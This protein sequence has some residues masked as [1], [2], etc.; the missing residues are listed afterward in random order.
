MTPCPQ[1]RDNSSPRAVSA[2]QSISESSATPDSE[3]T[4]RQPEVRPTEDSVIDLSDNRLST[5]ST[6]TDGKFAVQPDKQQGGVLSHPQSHRGQQAEQDA[7][8]TTATLSGA[9]DSDMP[10]VNPPTTPSG[11][12]D[13]S[14]VSEGTAPEHTQQQLY[15]PQQQSPSQQP[16][17][18]P[19]HAGGISLPGSSSMVSPGSGTM[20][21]DRSGALQ[22][23][24]NSDTMLL[25]SPG[26]SKGKDKA[27]L[28]R[29][30]AAAKAAAKA[31]TSLQRSSSDVCALSP[32]SSML[33]LLQRIKR[34][35]PGM[36]RRTSSTERPSTA[37][38][39]SSLQEDQPDNSPFAPCR[40]ASVVAM[41]KAE[42]QVEI[43][44]PQSVMLDS[45]DSNTIGV[46]SLGAWACSQD[47]QQAELKQQHLAAHA[48]DEA[49]A[50]HDSSISVHDVKLELQESEQPAVELKNDASCTPNTE[51]NTP[52]PTAT[53]A[54]QKQ[55]APDTTS[56]A[57]VNN[58]DDS[59]AD[60]VGS[61]Q[62]S[63]AARLRTAAQFAESI[64]R[65]KQSVQEMQQL[66]LQLQS[67]SLDSQ[68]ATEL[69]PL[70]TPPTATAATGSGTAPPSR[71]SSSQPVQ[72]PASASV[73]ATPPGLEVPADVGDI[74]S[75]GPH[76][77]AEPV[78]LVKQRLQ[79]ELLSSIWDLHATV[80]GLSCDQLNTG[81]CARVV[82]AQLASSERLQLYKPYANLCMLPLQVL[83]QAVAS[84]HPKGRRCNH[85]RC[86]HCTVSSSSAATQVLVAVMSL[87]HLPAPSNAG[88][89]AQLQMLRG[90]PALLLGQ[91]SVQGGLQRMCWRRS[92]HAS[93]SST[94]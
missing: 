6:V 89:A 22:M 17:G 48:I 23:R 69:L 21:S 45:H 31:A 65:F 73:Q 52:E 29:E 28:K 62:C 10:Q 90:H 86:S 94:Q 3:D 70:L 37:F 68:D 92:L 9:L 32:G 59:Q 58:S 91:D 61:G 78:V 35:M 7:Q 30:K 4:R 12:Q 14:L 64:G 20:S 84:T 49:A 76:N 82:T 15:T 67:L 57:Q 60:A 13:A 79:D 2:R 34:T 1:A 50:F 33:S 71:R 5:D 74:N 40:Q 85:G 25:S 66:W 24:R 8:I 83:Y 77:Q 81:R 19:Q 16:S 38:A 63:S 41:Q 46:D 47:K 87:V 43:A 56:L 72:Q 39:V 44:E 26:S 80:T 55:S 93:V 42:A 18:Q 54:A 53:D 36:R 27:Q 75:C 51:Y 11:Q 88:T